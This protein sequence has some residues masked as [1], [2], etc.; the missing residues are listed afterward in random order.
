[1]SQRLHP[2]ARFAATPGAMRLAANVWPPMLFTGIHVEHIAA[3]FRQ[4]RV[5]LG[6]SPLTLNMFRTQ[7]GGSMFAMTDPFWA[8]MLSVNLGPGYIVWDQRAEIEFVR[9]GRTALATEFVLT[10]DIVDEIRDGAADGER[11][12]RWFDNEICDRSGTIVAR[13]RK[14]VYVRQK[15][16]QRGVR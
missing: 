6:K 11:V 10:P 3:D 12:L 4:A 5:R 15:Q 9:P 13:V 16:A 1:M 14:Q 2:L 7:F 8:L